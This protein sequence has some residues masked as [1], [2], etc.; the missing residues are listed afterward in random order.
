MCGVLLTADGESQAWSYV[1]HSKSWD[2]S[3]C[4]MHSNVLASTHSTPN[5]GELDSNAGSEPRKFI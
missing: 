2:S 5:E 3:H 1:T 4:N